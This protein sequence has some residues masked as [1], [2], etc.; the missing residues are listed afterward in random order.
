M[1]SVRRLCQY[2]EHYLV[3]SHVDVRRETLVV[4]DLQTKQEVKKEI[5]NQQ[6]L[7]I[8]DS[9]LRA[10]DLWVKILTQTQPHIRVI[11][12]FLAHAL[13]RQWLNEDVVAWART[14]HSAT[15]LFEYIQ[16]LLPVIYN[17]SAYEVMDA[18]LRENP[19]VLIRWGRW[20]HLAFEYW[21]R[22]NKLQCIPYPWVSAYLTGSYE[23]QRV[24][25]RK[26]IVDLGCNLKRVESDLLLQ[27]QD[28]HDIEVI[29]PS[30]P[31]DFHSCNYQLEGDSAP[32]ENQEVLF[33][34]HIH[35]LRFSTMVAEVK[36]VT[37]KVRQW[38]DKGVAPKEIAVLSPNIEVYWTALR[39]YLDQEGVTVNKPVVAPLICQPEVLRWL[40]TLRLKMG[41]TLYE[42]LEL[43]EFT[44]FKKPMETFEKFH[45]RFQTLYSR[46]DL[47]RLYRIHKKFLNL[48]N[49]DTLCRDEF[50]ALGL[51]CWE[52][53]DILPLQDLFHYLFQDTPAYLQ[54]K[55]DQWVM[56][57]EELCAKREREIVASP[58]GIQFV[59][60]LSGPNH[61]VQYMY[62]MG[63]CESALNNP[64][65]T[66]IEWHEVLKIHQ[67]TGYVIDFI[68]NKKIELESRW[69]LEGKFKEVFVSCPLS[70]FA[71]HVEGPSR[72]WLQGAIHQK[73]HMKVQ[74]PE[75]SRW[76]EIQQASLEDLQR[77]RGWDLGK[78]LQD[79]PT[80]QKIKPPKK[81]TLSVTHLENYI[82][83]PFVFAAHKLFH[84][85]DLPFVEIDVDNLTKGRWIHAIFR[86][87]VTKA[88]F[89]E[90]KES[91]IMEVIESCRTPEDKSHIHPQMWEWMR[92]TLLETSK[93]FI[94]AERKIRARFPKLH[95]QGTEVSIEAD[96][97]L[98]NGTLVPRHSGDYEFKGS[99][100]RVDT[101]Q[102]SEASVIDYKLS[103]FRVTNFKSWVKG[104]ALQLS[105]YTQALQRGLTDLDPYEVGSAFYYVAKDMSREKGFRIKGKG[106][107]YETT[108]RDASGAEPVDI[109]QVQEQIMSKIQEVVQ[110]IDRGHFY[111]LPKDKKTCRTCYWRKMC[112]A[113]HLN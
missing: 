14:R 56:Y 63:L 106:D 2:N 13:I 36:D 94:E 60:I 48:Y 93:K 9:V 70:D 40:S 102:E 101:N 11:S 72:L 35:F 49:N 29:Q 24:W 47:K 17:E 112:R 18:W 12:P 110:E 75:A 86:K 43:T 52:G 4:A 34:P 16:Q 62:L 22:F 91:E 69:L 44:A 66:S 51:S 19:N 42:D 57:V 31:W 45:R 10:H 38:L 26:M 23:G 76:D 25:D 28:V 55:L 64:G 67:D 90:C 30:P 7:L 89:E 5:L 84:L 61:K 87:L 88:L 85:D 82:K 98:K 15:S 65:S 92:L 109:Q 97:D 41:R 58:E 39:F 77:V 111:P 74:Y 81:T 108:T 95:T 50:V 6:P 3:R 32:C 20:F 83:C 21:N 113:H 107:L 46:E 105:V 73:A 99:I 78:N 1:L 8:E 59:N 104:H 37:A 103:S 100:D 79:N 71:G 80:K 54:L 33:P 53:T 27:M 96:W 68:D